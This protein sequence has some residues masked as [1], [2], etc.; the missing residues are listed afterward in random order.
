MSC[1]ILYKLYQTNQMSWYLFTC[2][3]HSAGACKTS[4]VLAPKISKTTK[5][6]NRVEISTYK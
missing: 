4:Q 5:T 3:A 1:A 2:G 6:P